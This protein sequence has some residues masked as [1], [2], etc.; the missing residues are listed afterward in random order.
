VPNKSAALRFTDSPPHLDFGDV[1]D[2]KYY[3]VI[4]QYT[5]RL[6]NEKIAQAIRSLYTDPACP[7]PSKKQYNFRL[8]SPE[9]NERLTGYTHNGVTPLGTREKLPI[10]MS[11]LIADLNPAFFWLGAGEVDL[12]LRISFKEFVEHFQPLIADITYPEG[13]AAGA[14]NE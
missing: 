3:M 13:A 1:K 2:S 5:A 9:D 7:P 11:H 14:G 10:I 8:C 6:H 12:K 4:V